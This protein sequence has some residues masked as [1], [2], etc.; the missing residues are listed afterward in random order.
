MARWSLLMQHF[1]YLIIKPG[2]LKAWLSPCPG[3]PHAVLDTWPSLPTV[4]LSKF[5]GSSRPSSDGTPAIICPS[6][7]G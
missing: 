5:L 1:C 7:S 4:H 6:H 2:Q 3:P